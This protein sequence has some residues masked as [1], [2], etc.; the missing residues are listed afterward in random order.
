MRIFKLSS[1]DAE[2]RAKFI[3]AKKALQKAREKGDQD[4]VK[5]LTDVIKQMMRAEREEVSFLGK[6]NE[7][8]IRQPG[9]RSPSFGQWGNDKE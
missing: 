5:G 3:D 7:K 4:A 8:P 2:L 1:I 6:K 9:G